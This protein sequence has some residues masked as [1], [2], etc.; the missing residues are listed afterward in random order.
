MAEWKRKLLEKKQSEKQAETDK[1]RA[2]E[3]AKEA[4]CGTCMLR[5][6][7]HWQVDRRARMEARHH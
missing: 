6:R 3:L 2:I 5:R 7:S 1:L 4:R